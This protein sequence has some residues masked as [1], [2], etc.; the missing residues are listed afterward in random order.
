MS[1]L[2]IFRAEKNDFFARDRESP[3]TAEQK[4]SFAG[5]AYF[6]ENPALRLEVTAD[7][8]PAR[9]KIEMQTSTGEVQV[10]MRHSRLRFLLEGIDV[11][12]TV[13]EGPSGYFLPF[14]DSLA[15]TETYPAGRYLEPEALPGGRFL[16]DFNLAYNPYCAYN[17]QWSCPITPFENRLKVPIRAG[18]KLF[19][20]AIEH[21]HN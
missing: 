9:E 12:L 18:E 2:E 3:L 21:P 15:G 7:A 17:E 10:Y 19:H 11:E 5:L 1:E 14:V 13:Y 4:R 6:P 16:V 20:P 8:M